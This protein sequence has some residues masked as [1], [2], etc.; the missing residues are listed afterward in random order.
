M[1]AYGFAGGTIEV[2]MFALAL[3]PI[4]TTRAS[5]V[6]ACDDAPVALAR[7]HIATHAQTILLT[8]IPARPFCQEADTETPDGHR[9]SG[10]R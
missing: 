5:A 7:A 4:P 9:H 1:T 8:R 3:P 2:A 6:S 10:F